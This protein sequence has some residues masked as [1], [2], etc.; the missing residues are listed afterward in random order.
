VLATIAVGLLVLMES[1]V[2]RV[3]TG[4]VAVADARGEDLA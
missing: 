4:G 2:T 1:L 3:R